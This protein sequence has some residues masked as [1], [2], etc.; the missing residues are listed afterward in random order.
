MGTIK[1]HGYYKKKVCY[2]RTILIRVEKQ[3]RNS[4]VTEVGFKRSSEFYSVDILVSIQ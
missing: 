2:R 3:G 4:K 1:M